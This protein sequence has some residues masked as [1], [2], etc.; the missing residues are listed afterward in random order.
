[1]TEEQ[2]TEAIVLLRLWLERLDYSDPYLD[3]PR[4]KALLDSLPAA[5][6][7]SSTT[8]EQT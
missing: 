1:M 3:K 8:K 7:P 4:V 6:M 2:E 5:R